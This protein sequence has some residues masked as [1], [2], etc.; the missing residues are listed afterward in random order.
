[1]EALIQRIP[2]VP[3]PIKKST[4]NSFADSPFVDD[5]ALTEMPRKFNF[6]NM[7][8]Y[9][10]TTDPDDHIA[11]YKQ[12]MFTVAIPHDLR[13]ACMCKTFGSSLNGPALQWY[14][15]LPNN[16]INSFAQLTDTLV[17]QFASSRKLEK[18]SDDL[19]T[20]TQRHGKNLRTYVG[21][22]NREKVQIPHCNQATAIYAFRKGLRFDS[23]LYKELTKYPCRTMED[24]LAKACAQIKWEEDEANFVGKVNNYSNRR[25]DQVDKKSNDRKSEPYSTEVLEYNLSIEPV[26]L[27]S[28]MKEMSKTIKWPRKMNALPEYRDEFLTDKGKQT[29]ARRDEKRPAI[30]DGPPDPL[31]Q[32]RVI[33]YIAEGSEVSGVSYSMAKKHTR[34]VSNAEIQPN[35]EHPLSTDETITF[36]STDKSDLFSSHHDALIISLHIAN[37][38]TKRIVIDNGSSCNILFISAL[39]EMQ[40]DETKLSRRTTM[41]TGFSGE[42]KNTLGEIALDTQDEGNPIDISSNDQIHN[43]MRGMGNKRGDLPKT[44]Q[45]NVCRYAW[46]DDEG[47]FLGYLVTR[48]G[49]KANPDQIRSIQGI[50]S[51]RCIKD[52]QKLTGRVA[53]LNRFISK[54]FKRRHPFFNTLR[55]N[56]A[57]EW[58]DSCKK[59]LQDLKHYLTTPPLLSKPK[60]DEI[61]LVYLAV[62]DTAVSAVLIKEE[63]NIQHLVYYVS[64]ALLDTETRY[65]R[66]E[67]LALALVVA[68]QKL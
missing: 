8:Q 30:N 5:I 41:L 4:T 17:E 26:D 56:K 24:M 36:K 16:S 27:V 44:C 10:G 46:N 21:R 22:F 33:N 9:E 20:I 13:E 35:R 15:N 68:A 40:V 11:Q 59:A 3:A 1:M 51:P 31:R 52:I 12:R 34:Q 38:L 60:D 65:S 14:T 64:K 43:K 6:P 57:F 55:K 67:K 45:Q 32:D 48:R 47:K 58:N 49:I 37:C 29:I 53:A 19:Y 63:G 2:R 25:N 61:L 62:S 39:R 7:K 23:H 50:E 54:S 28:L 66:L 18:Q 42:Q